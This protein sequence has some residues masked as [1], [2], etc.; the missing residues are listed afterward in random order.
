M[1]RY[2]QRIVDQ[3][4]YGHDQCAK[5]VRPLNLI[6][7]LTHQWFGSILVTI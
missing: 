1:N 7:V 2:A 4:V 3:T 6:R 5:G